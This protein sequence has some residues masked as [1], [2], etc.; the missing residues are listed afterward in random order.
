VQL[1]RAL[2]YSDCTEIMIV[3]ASRARFGDASIPE[4]L[5]SH[6][7]SWKRKLQTAT[8]DACDA[9]AGACDRGSVVLDL[10]STP[11]CRSFRC[12]TGSLATSGDA[13]T[14]EALSA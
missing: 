11:V 9:A 7:A 1:E 3:S 5:D 2:L 4:C 6:P 10:T 8:H 14:S 13:C 12:I